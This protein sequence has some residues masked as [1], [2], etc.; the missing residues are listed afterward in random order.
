[1]K[2]FL[3]GLGID[4]MQ[5]RHSKPKNIKFKNFTGD[6]NLDKCCKVINDFNAAQVKM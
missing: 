3:F 6:A 4:G 5:D 2:V 1:M